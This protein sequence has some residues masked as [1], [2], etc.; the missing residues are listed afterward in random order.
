MRT[1][2]PWTWQGCSSAPSGLVPRGGNRER[3]EGSIWTPLTHPRPRDEPRRERCCHPPLHQTWT[4]LPMSPLGDGQPEGPVIRQGPPLASPPAAPEQ[5]RLTVTCTAHTPRSG[6]GQASCGSTELLRTGPYLSKEPDRGSINKSKLAARGR[7]QGME[8]RPRAVIC[9]GSRALPR[10]P[11]LKY[12]H[13]SRA[14]GQG[15]QEGAQNP[16]VVWES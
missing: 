8:S 5:A 11:V 2:N 15:E 12:S 14:L 10:S 7:S 6:P 9:A 13:S 1:R 16:R 3:D 4:R